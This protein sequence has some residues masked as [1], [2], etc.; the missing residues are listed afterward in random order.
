MVG[1]VQ[2]DHHKLDMSTC[3]TQMSLRWYRRC[4]KNE[5]RLL[6]GEYCVFETEEFRLEIVRNHLNDGAF[7]MFVR[8][9]WGLVELSGLG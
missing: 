5:M 3:S 8:S 9:M 4:W 6:G 7:S 2:E 1:V